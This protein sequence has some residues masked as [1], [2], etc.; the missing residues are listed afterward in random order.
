[1]WES[2]TTQV[3]KKL[4]RAGSTGN[5][6]D[7]GNPEELFRQPNP[8][9]EDVWGGTTYYFHDIKMGG[10]EGIFT[11]KGIAII[12]LRYGTEEALR[13]GLAVEINSICSQ[14]TNQKDQ[15]IGFQLPLPIMSYEERKDMW[16]ILGGTNKF[17]GKQ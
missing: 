6:F 15:E 3:D 8:V 7:R 17:T 9:R 14:E 12:Q 1:M 11:V 13:N 4:G 2:K 16:E 5:P 10:E